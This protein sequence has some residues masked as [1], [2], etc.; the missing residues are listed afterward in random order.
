MRDALRAMRLVPGFMPRSRST[1]SRRTRRSARPAGDLGRFWRCPR[2]F[3]A[4]RRERSTMPSS[5]ADGAD[6]RDRQR[7]S[8]CAAGRSV[9]IR[10]AEMARPGCRA[11]RGRR[12]GCAFE[13]RHDA[14]ASRPP[15]CQRTPRPRRATSSRSPPSLASMRTSSSARGREIA[16][17]AALFIDYGHMTTGLGDTLQGVAAR[18]MCRRSM[19]REKRISRCR[20]TSSASPPS[21]AA[22][23]STTDGPCRRPSSWPPRHHRARLAPDGRQSRQGA[24]IE[25]GVAR[26]MAPTG[27]GSRFKAIGLRSPAFRRCRDLLQPP[28]SG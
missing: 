23:A 21:A 16:P 19:R 18:L 14:P 12:I 6:D 11:R 15:S 24:A 25:T 27:M 9:R 3:T 17:L 5:M 7:V 20:S 22:R 1:S 2:I 26:L 13:R 4:S 10:R 8:R 28:H